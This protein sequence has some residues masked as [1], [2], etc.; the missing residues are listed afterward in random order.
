M[1]RFI[2]VWFL[3]RLLILVVYPIAEVITIQ[4]IRVFVL[5][6]HLK[7]LLILLGN[8]SRLFGFFICRNI[9]ESFQLGHSSYPWLREPGHRGLVV[10]LPIFEALFDHFPV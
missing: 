1:P 10:V 8:R 5:V 3:F 2:L 4:G 6:D 7:I 9:F